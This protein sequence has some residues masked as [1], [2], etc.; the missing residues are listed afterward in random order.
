MERK[1]FAVLVLVALLYVTHPLLLPIG[2][3]GVLA[4]LFAPWMDR[5]ERKK[6]SNSLGSALVTLGVTVVL[7]LPASFLISYLARAGFRQFQAWKP[8]SGSDGGFLDSV[9]NLPNVQGTLRRLTQW[10]PT[11]T[12]DLVVTIEQWVTGISGKVAEVAGSL[13]AQ[14]PSVLLALILVVISLYFFLADRKR[15]LYW[16]RRNE[17]FELQQTDQLIRAMAGLCRSVILAA[18]VSGAAQGL[19]EGIAVAVAGMSNAV[20]IGSL[21]FIGSFIPLVGA[22]P[23]TLGVALQA[24]LEGHQAAGIAL[25]IVAMVV[26]GIDNAIRPMILKG[27]ANLHPLLAFVAAIG[28]LETLGVFGVFLGPILAGLVIAIIQIMSEHRPAR[29][30]RG[31]AE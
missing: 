5:L 11:T 12:E 9:L 13:V 23:I 30:A 24:L 22:A 4:A 15:I 27:S 17:I 14:V 6:I 20:L 16:V 18:I 10:F 8:K 3:G 26:G 29:T 2:M 1:I 21:V 28:G 19:L 25:L 31:G 7:I